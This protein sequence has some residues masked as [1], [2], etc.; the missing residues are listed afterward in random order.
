MQQGGGFVETRPGLSSPE[1]SPAT[2]PDANGPG[3]APELVDDR[4]PIP[5]FPPRVLDAHGRLIPLSPEER[6]ARRDAAIRVLKSLRGLPDDDP[7]GTE[8]AMMRGIDE[9]RPHRPLF[10]GMY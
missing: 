3:Q 9:G 8:E 4:G 7:P 6:A 2:G 5:T 1:P 10:E